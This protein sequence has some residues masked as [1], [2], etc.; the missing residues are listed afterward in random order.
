LVSRFTQN[1]AVISSA[2]VAGTLIGGGLGWLA[3]R[4][5]DQ[6]RDKTYSVKAMASDVAYFTPA[7]IILGLCIYDPAIY[8]VS[9]HLLVMG[10][11]VRVS[12]VVG[13]LVAF[14]LFLLSLNIY[15]LSLFMVRGKSL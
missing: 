15:R 2:A 7:A 1:A 11:G 10:T 12:V 9:H 13:Q 6:V 4:I 14:V 3:T 8:L 5:Y